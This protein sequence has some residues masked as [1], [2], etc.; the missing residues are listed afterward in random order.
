MDGFVG[1]SQR[2]GGTDETHRIGLTR[3]GMT[4][5]AGCMG[6]PGSTLHQAAGEV[7]V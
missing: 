6:L 2:G 7:E 5:L 3:F 4:M 1:G